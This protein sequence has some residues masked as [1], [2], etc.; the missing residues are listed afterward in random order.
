[1][2]AGHYLDFAR[3]LLVIVMTGNTPDS[4]TDYVKTGIVDQWLFKP[5]GLDELKTLL[6]G[7]TPLQPVRQPMSPTHRPFPGRR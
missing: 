2:P 5:F 4:V 6:K 1:L 7:I 3:I